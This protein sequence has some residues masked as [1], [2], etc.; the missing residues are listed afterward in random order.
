[1]AMKNSRALV[2]TLTMITSPFAQVPAIW[3]VMSRA[4]AGAAAIVRS[5]WA[6]LARGTGTP[7]C[8]VVWQFCNLVPFFFY[9]YNH[10]FG[11]CRGWFIFFQLNS[12]NTAGPATGGVTVCQQ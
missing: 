8:V 9:F 10:S 1:M 2:T 6:G 12:A 3:L 5:A 7:A 4:W 11:S